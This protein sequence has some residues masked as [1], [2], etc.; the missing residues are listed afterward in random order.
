LSALVTGIAVTAAIL[1]DLLARRTTGRRPAELS[2]G[3]DWILAASGRAES[4]DNRL[5][6]IG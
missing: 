3:M 6:L 1:D 4:S 5:P 2:D